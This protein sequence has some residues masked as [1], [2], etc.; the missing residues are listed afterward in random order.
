[1]WEAA[2]PHKRAHCMAV[3]FAGILPPHRQAA[4]G[5][6]EP[7]PIPFTIFYLDFRCA[8]ACCADGGTQAGPGSGVRVHAV[9]C[10]VLA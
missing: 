10:P 7:W 2:G 3:P 9:F 4:V 5:P 1:M 8:A 6:E